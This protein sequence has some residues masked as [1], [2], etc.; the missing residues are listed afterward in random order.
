MDESEELDLEAVIKELEEEL[1]ESE[2]GEEEESV[3]EG[4]HEDD[5]DDDDEEDEEGNGDDE[6]KIR[7][8]TREDGR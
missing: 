8:A 1:N 5:E 2:P 3:Q 6:E 7:D 4:A